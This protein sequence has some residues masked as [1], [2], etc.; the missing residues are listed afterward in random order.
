MYQ[1][2]IIILSS[3]HKIQTNHSTRSAGITS[4]KIFAFT[5]LLPE[6][7]RFVYTPESIT[8]SGALFGEW[9]LGQIGGIS[10][11]AQED[12]TDNKI[13]CEK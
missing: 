6:L 7:I 3:N 4:L 8:D 10:N 5:K 11:A 1:I 9:L 12:V 2:K 13:L